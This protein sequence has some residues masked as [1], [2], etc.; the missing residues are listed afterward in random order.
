M[1]VILN[2]VLSF[3]E[4]KAIRIERIESQKCGSPIFGFGAPFEQDYI[5][6]LKKTTY[7]LGKRLLFFLLIYTFEFA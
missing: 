2:Y 7:F 5:T 4:L 3:R 1:T 6:H